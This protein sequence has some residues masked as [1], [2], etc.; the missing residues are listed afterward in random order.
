MFFHKTHHETKK[1][2]PESGGKTPS[3][4]G[5]RL[6]V[7]FDLEKDKAGSMI[8]LGRS[9]NNMIVVMNPNVSKFHAYFRD[10][11]S[12]M[13]EI[14]DGGSTNG[15]WVDGKTLLKDSPVALSGGETISFSAAIQATFE[16]PQ[17][18][19]DLVSIGS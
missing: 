3:E 9:P 10:I 1:G 18:M 15:T 8:P 17:T 19:Y 11:G 2:A 5:S 14:A 4:S 12:D 16:S 6:L 7:Y 13:W